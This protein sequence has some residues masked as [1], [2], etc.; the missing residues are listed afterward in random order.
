MSWKQISKNWTLEKGRLQRRWDKLTAGDLE[1]INGDRNRLVERL[2][3][4]YGFEK[5]D[6]NRRIDEWQ[7]ESADRLQAHDA[8]ERASE[9]SFPASDPPSFTPQ[10]SVRKDLSDSD[11][12]VTAAPKKRAK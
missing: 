10:T 1:V 12:N 3:A 5:D 2:H 11:D 9:E 7:E 6:A 8:V 4:R